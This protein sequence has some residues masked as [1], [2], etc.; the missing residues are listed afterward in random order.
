M[1]EEAIWSY[2]QRNTRTMEKRR[3]RR[4][5]DSGSSSCSDLSFDTSAKIP[6]QVSKWTENDLNGLSIKY[7]GKSENPYDLLNHAELV[8]KLENLPREICDMV[9]F[10]DECFD[11]DIATTEKGVI[12][13]DALCQYQYIGE[14]G[15][16]TVT[17]L[18][19]MYESTDI[20]LSK[21]TSS[22]SSLRC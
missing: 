9:T 22:P 8:C 4:R 12:D 18:D 15:R 2:L 7:A 5:R 1:D 21:Y 10:L 6:S 19:R 20:H 16:G 13:I 3:K 11:F 17:M 14:Q